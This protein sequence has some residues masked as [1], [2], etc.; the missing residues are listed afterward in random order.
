MRSI[1]IPDLVRLSV[2]Q[3][4]REPFI[5]FSSNFACVYIFITPQNGWNQNLWEN[6]FLAPR[7]QKNPK[8]TLKCTFCCISQKLVIWFVWIFAYSWPITKANKWYS[9]LI[10]ENS[11]LAP[12]GQKP[13]KLPKII[14]TC[15]LLNLELWFKCPYPY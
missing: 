11:F 6:S 4:S 15:L 13:P 9:L 5:R 3:I 2:P 10:W 14:I 1:S 8:I 7:G 12:R